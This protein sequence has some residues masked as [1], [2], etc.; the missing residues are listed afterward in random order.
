MQSVFT[1]LPLTHACRRTAL[2]PFS[3][4]KG[5]GL[6]AARRVCF[7]L[8]NTFV[9]FFQFNFSISVFC[10]LVGKAS[11]LVAHIARACPGFCSIK[12]RKLFLL[13][14]GTDVCPPQSYRHA[15][16]PPLH[17]PHPALLRRYVFEVLG[18]F[19]SLSLPH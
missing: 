3:N 13:P 12:R 5:W 10:G 9:L 17:P 16:T 2:T 18:R 11:S 7:Q 15:T 8:F 4:R 14:A 19:F 6:H 1:P